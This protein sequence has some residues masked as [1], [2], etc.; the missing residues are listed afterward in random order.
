MYYGNLTPFICALKAFSI[1]N[2]LAG[3]S[4]GQP[5]KLKAMND[6]AHFQMNNNL[7]QT[8]STGKFQILLVYYKSIVR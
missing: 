3:T 5:V 2:N 1:P 4:R 8:Y 6:G 7:K